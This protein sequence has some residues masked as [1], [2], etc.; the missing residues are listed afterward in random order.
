MTVRKPS[1]LLLAAGFNLVLIQ[2]LI[3]RELS[4]TL[5]CTEL[6]V[7]L[8]TLGYFSGHLL[9][10]AVYHKVSERATRAWLIFSL[11]F[12]LPAVPAVRILSAWLAQHNHVGLARVAVFLFC[13][14]FLTSFYAIFLPRIVDSMEDRGVALAGAYRAELA[15]GGM[16]LLCGAVAGARFLE[17][18][19]VSYLFALLVIGWSLKLSLRGLTFLAALAGL[20][21]ARLPQ[22]DHY[23]SNYFY[24]HYYGWFKQARVIHSEHTP[25]QKIEVVEESNG[26]RYLYLN[27]LEYFGAGSLELFNYYLSGV[28]GRIKPGA[29]VLIVGSGSMSSLNHLAPNVSSITT[30]EIDRRVA[31]VGREYFSDFNRLE[32]LKVPWNLVIDDAKHYLANTTETYDLIIVDIPAPY[33][34]QT[35]MLFTREFYQLAED[36]LSSGGLLSIYLPEF[37]IPGS[38][39]GKIAR[40]ILAAVGVVFEEFLVINADDAERSFVLAGSPLKFELKGLLDAISHQGRRKFQLLSHGHEAVAEDL[41]GVEPASFNHLKVVWELTWWAARQ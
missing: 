29:R 13:S 14:L 28:P 21:L 12:H 35:G 40:P 11:L 38:E 22:F 16:A 7:M 37:Y 32:E 2:L 36:R 18:A 26:E 8:V 17:V 19:A 5:F 20:V 1:L 27:G 9:G 39:E 23:S 34:L 25:Y 6:V 30:V 41:A 15:G 24:N 31:E 10:Y 4:I 33:Y 3:V